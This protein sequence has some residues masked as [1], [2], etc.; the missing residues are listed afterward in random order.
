MEAAGAVQMFQRSISFL[1]LRYT[2]YIGDGDSKAH[3]CVVATAP[4]GDQGI[5]KL[6]CV[7]HV[8]K[9][10]GTRLRNFTQSF[11]GQK[12]ADGKGI[13]GKNRL[14]KKVIKTIQKYYGMVIRQN[15]NNI[16]TMK[17]AIIAIL[18]HCSENISL[19]DK[20]KFC[21]RSADSWCKYQ[22]NKET[23]DSTYKEKISLPLAIRDVLKPIFIYLSSNGLLE[24]CAHDLTQNV[25][26]ALHGMLWSRCPNEMYNARP[27]VEMA[28]SSA[29]FNFNDGGRRIEE[30]MKRLGIA[31]MEHG[32]KEGT[33]P[34]K[35]Q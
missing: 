5:K 34:C 30:V 29:V 15:L 4:Y 14:T 8:Q 16:Y 20:Y 19:E 26:E 22:S 1:N 28:A 12:L 18:F 25:N 6:E 11:R 27:V 24:K 13:S 23:R 21:P 33:L 10:M 9:I 35:V 17:K 3:Q 32:V 31:P 7:G 2:G